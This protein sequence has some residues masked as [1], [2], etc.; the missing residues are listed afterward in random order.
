MPPTVDFLIIGGGLA[1][2]TAMET[3]LQCEIDGK[4]IALV[5]AETELPYHRPPL[6]KGYLLGRASRESVFVKPRAFYQ[7]AGVSLFL[8]TRAT[9]LHPGEKTVD[10]DRGGSLRYGKLLLAHG[11]SLKRLS[12]PG[13]DL[14]GIFYLRTLADADRLIAA[15]GRRTH[16]VVVGGSFI[17]M[18]LASAFAQRGIKTTLL[19]RGAQVFDKLESPEASRFF[20]AVF[21]EHGVTIRTEDAAV[22]FERAAGRER[23]LKVTTK[24]GDML[25]ADLVAAGVGVAPDTDWLT[26]SGLTIDNGIVV[27]EYLEASL[28][29]VYAAGDIANFF[30]PLYG[31]QRRIEHWAT[32]I[33]HGKAA[34][35]TMAGRREPYGAVSYFFSDIFDLSFEY[36]G[37]AS[38]TT[39]T[40]ERGSF[41]ERAVTIFYLQERTVRAAFTLGRPKERKALIQL[42]AARRPADGEA[43]ANVHHPLPVLS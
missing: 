9:A 34:G 15:S 17:G 14:P 7:T 5:G 32:A 29:D 33:D 22:A 3:L 40:I 16:A 19:H 6:S 20:H 26:S 41:A 43:L 18:E 38:G 24:R 42:I 8:G 4:R 13:G 28:P 39:A 1:A 27:N 35:A 21:T 31:R 30:D 25:A 2:A 11:C 37:D 10:T 12:V 36:F 23:R